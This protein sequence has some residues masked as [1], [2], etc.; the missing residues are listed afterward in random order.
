MSKIKSGLQASAGEAKNSAKVIAALRA[1]CAEQFPY[2]C[3]GGDDN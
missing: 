3:T 1:Y 2:V